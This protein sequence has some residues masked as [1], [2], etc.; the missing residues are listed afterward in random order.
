MKVLGHCV[1]G[2]TDGEEQKAQPRKENYSLLRENKRKLG[3]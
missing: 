2:Y 1:L 3:K